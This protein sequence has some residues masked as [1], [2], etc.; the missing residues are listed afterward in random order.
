MPDQ[1]NRPAHKVA[2]WGRKGGLKTKRKK[3]KN[4]YRKIA[5]MRKSFKGGRPPKNPQE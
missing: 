4:F 5:A 1:T 2:A 3:G